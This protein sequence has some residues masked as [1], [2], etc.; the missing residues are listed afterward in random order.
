[1]DV[2]LQPRLTTSAFDDPDSGDYHTQTRWQIFRID[3]GACVYDVVGNS[4]LTTVTVPSSTLDAFTAY[5]WTARYYDQNGN[6]SAPAPN[7]EFTTRQLEEGEVSSPSL[8]SSGSGSG[9]GSG[10]GNSDMVNGC[11][12][13]ILSGLE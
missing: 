10:G 2:S 11:F 3:N 6:V 13:G 4:D 12:I 8:I 1:M 5:Y 7:A 9:G